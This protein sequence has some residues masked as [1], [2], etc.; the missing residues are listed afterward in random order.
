MDS[1]WG[2]M[3]MIDRLTGGDITKD[4][5]VFELQWLHCL[6]RLLYWKKKDEYIEKMNKAQEAENKSKYGRRSR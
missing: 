3:G 4:N 5:E 6:N 1:K 2:H